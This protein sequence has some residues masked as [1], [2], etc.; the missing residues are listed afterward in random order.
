TDLVGK[1]DALLL[2]PGSIGAI[3]DSIEQLIDRL[4]HIDL[5]FITDNL[6]ALFQRV[7]AKLEAISPAAL[8]QLLD[9]AFADMLGTL[10]LSVVL[11]ADQVGKLDQDFAAVI[12]KLQALDP[13]NLVI[14]VVQP[15]FDQK[16]QPLLLAFDLS[17]LIQAVI[18]A[19]DQLKGELA[20]E[21]DRVNQSYKAMLAAVPS[22]SPLSISV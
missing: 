19:L 16:I 22:I 8:G 12:T 1:V 18:D 14:D 15:K 17:G 5:G 10:D 13:K 9:Q 6:S 21:L 7:R 2:G 11:P 3:K 4:T 20:G